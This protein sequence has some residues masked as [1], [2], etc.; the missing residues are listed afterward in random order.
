MK[1]WMAVLIALMVGIPF[2]AALAEEGEGI[3]PVIPSLGGPKYNLLTPIKDMLSG[4]PWLILSGKDPALSKGQGFNAIEQANPYATSPRMQAGGA[5]LVPFRDPAPAFSRGVL[6]TRD[7]SASPFQT[8]PHMAVSPDDPDHI[9]VGVIDYAFDSLVSYVS[10]DG[11]SSWEGPYQAPYPSQDLASAGDPVLAFDRKGRVYMAGISLGIEEFNLG[12]LATESLVSSISIAR[13]DDGGENWIQSVSSSR[14]KVSTQGLQQDRF[15]RT[16]GTVSVGFLD[17]PWLAIGPDPANKDND[18]IYVVYTDFEEQAELYYLGEVPV[19]VGRDLLTT[20]RMVASRDQ[21]KTWSDPISVSPTV[22]RGSS[23]GG[24][25]PDDPDRKFLDNQ[26]PGAAPTAEGRKRI[27]QGPQVNV[28]KDGTVYFSWMDSLDDDNT[29]GLGEIQVATST[30]GGKTIKR[31]GAAATFNEIP[32]KPRTN[33]F[34]F[35][36]SSFPQ[37][38]LGPNGEIYIIYSGRPPDKAMDDAD[39]YLVSSMDKGLT[40]SRPM[41]LNGDEGSALQFLPAIDVDP[42]GKLHVMWLDTRDDKTRLRYHVYYTTSEDKGKTWG[43]EIKQIGQRVRDARVSDFSTNPNRAFPGGAFIGDYVAIKSTDEDVYLIWPDGRLAEFG[44][45][46]QKIG[47]AR[48]RPINSPAVSVT[49][50]AGAGGQSVVIQGFSFQPESEILVQLGDAIISSTRSNSEGRFTLNLYMPL[51]AEGPQTVRVFDASGN[52]ASASYFTEFGFNNLQ[53]SSRDLK[54]LQDSFKTLQDSYK[55]LFDLIK[56]NTTTQGNQTTAS[57]KDLQTSVSALQ[58]SQKDLLSAVSA[59]TNNAQTAST[60]VKELQASLIALQASQ[61]TLLDT[62]NNGVTNSAQ[63]ANSNAQAANTNAQ[64]ANN[65]IKELQTAITALQAS[66]K[67]LLEALTSGLTTN[68]QSAQAANNNAQAANSG[69][70][71]LQNAITALQDS[72]KSIMDSL[73]T[74]NVQTAK[75]LKD[76]QSSVSGLQ[77]SNQGLQVSNQGLQT[78]NKELQASLAALQNSYR[79]L[80]NSFTQ[81]QN[82]YKGLQAAYQDMMKRLDEVN[83]KLPLPTPKK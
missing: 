51:T 56:S 40:W 50:P 61:K 75:D 49:P 32:Y 53:G 63:A 14:S 74:A 7:F 80:Q 62:V 44:G 68:A 27:V 28:G 72:Q 2:S 9:V 5:G 25:D 30:D 22:R 42:K 57:V 21:G 19:L 38:A 3:K 24:S 37:T 64:A 71:E 10:Y 47:F 65:S 79:E 82:N 34:R 26:Q 55:E 48:Q 31:L 41:R 45:Y 67:S 77:A 1:R 17:K 12:P 43:F 66:Q 29:K 4:R 81:L 11:G 76:L 36:A 52:G 15:G 35:W 39:V 6:I 33:P 60:A 8:E 69:I 83:K 16:R 73:S 13:S 78:V 54:G 58:A 70:K 23:E 20:I 18:I 46:N 59:S